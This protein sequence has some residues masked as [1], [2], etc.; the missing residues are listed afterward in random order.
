MGTEEQAIRKLVADWHS[1]TAA[2]NVDAI[3]PLMANDVVFF[4]AGQTPFGRE[5]F[6][7]GLRSILHTHRI[8]S[9]GE[10]KEIQVS[11]DM[12][13]CWSH[14]NVSVYPLSGSAPTIRSGNALSVLRKQ[15]SGT[16]Q[17]TRDANMLV[18][19]SDA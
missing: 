6:E 19:S 3:L 4:V 15:P 1:S 8:E 10:I 7:K 16:W 2:G 18:A 14:L 12:A 11:G 17:I 5:T 9:S 13:Y